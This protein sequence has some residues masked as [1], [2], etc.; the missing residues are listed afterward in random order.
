VNKGDNLFRYSL[1]G[2]KGEYMNNFSYQ[3]SSRKSSIISVC[4]D[5][6]QRKLITAGLD[7]FA[8]PIALFMFII[9]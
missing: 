7:G 9:F 6:S 4:F 8:C 5:S 3:E 2:D 1:L